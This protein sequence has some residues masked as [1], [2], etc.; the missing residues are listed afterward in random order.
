MNTQRACGES[1][2]CNARGASKTTSNICDSTSR[3]LDAFRDRCAGSQPKATYQAS[4]SPGPGQ[5]E[6][7][8]AMGRQEAFVTKGAPNHDFVGK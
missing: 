1:A 6:T 3:Q 7:V 5:A 2:L 8:K 4:L